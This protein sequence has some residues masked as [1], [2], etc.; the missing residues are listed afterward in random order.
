[1]RV[2]IYVL[3]VVLAV[4]GS[5]SKAADTARGSVLN[6]YP[7]AVF[8]DGSLSVVPYASQFGTERYGS[9]FGY[10]HNDA[11]RSSAGDVMG[12]TPS[13]NPVSFALPRVPTSEPRQEA[14]ARFNPANIPLPATRTLEDHLLTAFVALM[15]IAYQLR[16]KHR[17]LRPHQFST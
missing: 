3:G 6:T 8:A 14:T 17:F 15:L 10:P 16:R 9:S 5:T 12:F 1:M 7:A 11:L 4:A 13:Q 2:A